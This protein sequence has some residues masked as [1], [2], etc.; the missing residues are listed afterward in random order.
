MLLASVWMLSGN[1]AE[2]T[3]YYTSCEGHHGQALLS[4]LS[5]KIAS[6]T[7][8]SYDNLWS[9]YK[10]SD[11][12]PDGTLWDIYTTKAW[13]SNFTKCGNYK[14][15]GDCVNKEHSLP[16]SWWGGGK[17]TPQYSDAY[18]LYPTDGRVNGQRSNFPYGECSGGSRLA[19]NGSVRALGRLGSSTFSGYSG[20]VFEPDDEYKGDLARTYFYMATAYNSQIGGWTQGN[21][22]QFFAGNS[23]PVFKTW[24]LELLLKWHR[25]D[26]VSQ[27]EI[28][29][30]EAVYKHQKNRNP[31]IDHPEL[32]EY[33]WGSKN[34]VDWTLNATAD[35]EI[36]T[37][38]E[39]TL[40]A[41]GTTATG[42]TRSRK[43]AVKG[44]SLTEVLTLSVA[45]SGFSVTPT[46]VSAADANKGTE[47]TVSYRSTATGDAGGQLILR[48]GSVTRAVTLTAS[49]VDGIPA[50]PA[51]NISDTSFDAVWSNIDAENATYTLTVSR[52]GSPV[53]G[54]PKS[55]SARA[56]S[57][58]VTD[59]EPETAYTYTVSNGTLTSDPVA[60]TTLAPIPSIQFLFD[61]D[62]EF[63]AE[64]GQPSEV[65][66]ILADIE[67]IPGDIT[68]TVT[69]P[70]QLSLDKADWKTQ[71]VLAPGQDRFY[72]RLFGST[73][74]EYSTTLLAEAEDFTDDFTDVDG[75]IAVPVIEPTFIEDFE[76]GVSGSYDD[77]EYTGSACKWNTDAYIT[78]E[79]GKGGPYNGLI[80]ARMNK[81]K[82]GHLT[83]LEDKLN[84]MGVLT[85]QAKPWDG[86]ESKYPADITVSV[87]SDHGTTWEEV[88]KVTISADDAASPAYRKYSVTI[89]RRGSLRMKMEQST[90]AR[91][92]IDDIALTDCR[93]SGIQEAM[94]AEYHSWD[95]YC[96][97]GR[98]VL[99]SREDGTDVATVY[100]MDGVLR[101]SGA[102][103]RGTTEIAVAPG[104]Y[105]VVVRDFTRT[106]L[107][108]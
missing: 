22:N 13:P 74:G 91:T 28:D 101:H 97:N 49:A 21:G 53:E 102:I 1:A 32:V 35:P 31:Y 4:A 8:V 34:T 106:V 30:N 15:I 3:G 85:F 98:L 16:K 105:L 12:R 50:G 75:T 80:C 68:L 40:I 36:V 69:A 70:F 20:T 73:E 54:F 43:V 86:D 76:K 84:G 23:Y 78:K 46:S 57:Y 56:E 64:P 25:Q 61:G 104:L 6:H 67:N 11:M 52:G 100:S 51:V 79:T 107:V 42:V 66:E 58:T 44:A 87:S 72:M 37:P 99:E 71:I 55:V 2:P 41:V 92:L 7:K 82:G 26:P 62:L 27:K 108:K 83:M 96:R 10:D 38:A 29:R 60:V 63:F 59:L 24:S 103:A 95:A 48:S 94:E 88:G 9:V 65:A 19:N 47:V 33:I 93:T 39:G 45:G 89:N 77:K 90:N 81:N 18:H 5:S 14:V 17:S